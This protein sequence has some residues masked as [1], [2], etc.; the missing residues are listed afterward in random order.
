M[1]G[2]FVEKND[3][4]VA[5]EQRRERNTPA[6]AAAQIAQA[7]IPRDAADE[8]GDDVTDAA[9]AGPL[10]FIPIA[11]DRVGNDEVIVEFVGLVKHPEGHSASTG[12]PAVIGLDA[13]GQQAKQRGLAVTVSTDDSD[14][15][16]FVD[17]DRHG[18]KDHPRRVCEV[19][20]FRSE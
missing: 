8:P 18:I 20:R 11:D 6:L 13:A 10:V 19:K 1:V 4:P 17:A 3:I 12:H 15:L 14:S 9:I 5:D 7:G 16:A 2:R